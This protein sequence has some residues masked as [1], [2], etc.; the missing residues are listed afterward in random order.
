MCGHKTNRQEVYIT[1]SKY[2]AKPDYY[3]NQLNKYSL[4]IS[5]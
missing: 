4:K 3:N 5:D 2:I 1:K